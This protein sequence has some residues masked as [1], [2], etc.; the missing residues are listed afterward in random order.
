[1]ALPFM[2]DPCG[3]LILSVRLPFASTTAMEHGVKAEQEAACAR[4]AIEE[5]LRITPH[6]A[7]FTGVN[8][9]GRICRRWPNGKRLRPDVSCPDFIWLTAN[10]VFSLK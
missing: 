3:R 6:W 9:L 4:L 8:R 5:K 10:P 2:M 7:I 1:V